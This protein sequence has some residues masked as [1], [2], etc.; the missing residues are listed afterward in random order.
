MPLATDL[1]IADV[2]VELGVDKKQISHRGLDGIRLEER[3]FGKG[4]GDI[5]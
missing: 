5:L 2:A 4:A 1:S 3:L